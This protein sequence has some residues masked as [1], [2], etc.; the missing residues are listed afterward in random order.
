ML[1]NYSTFNLIRPVKI[2][3]TSCT[4]DMTYNT[5]AN[6]ISLEQVIDSVK[7]QLISRPAYHRNVMLDPFSCGKG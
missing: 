7:E 2:R 5:A 3:V 4:Q 6:I 1:Y